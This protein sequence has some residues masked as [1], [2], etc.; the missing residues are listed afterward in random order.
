MNDV[1][2]Y[3]HGKI[4]ADGSSIRLASL[5][6]SRN[7]ANGLHRFQPFKAHGQNRRTL[8]KLRDS[9]EKWLVGNMCVMLSQQRFIETHHFTTHHFQAFFLESSDYFP[10]EPALQSVRFDED[11]RSFHA[12]M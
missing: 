7:E 4:T 3:A 6:D 5:C 11:K 2:R 10:H 12:H 9:R 1:A 8:H